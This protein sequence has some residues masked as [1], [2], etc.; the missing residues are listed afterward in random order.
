MLY[1]F[2]A[3]GTLTPSRDGSCG[4]FSFSLLPGVKQ[5]CAELQAAGH[6]LAIASNQSKDRDIAAILT[7]LTWTANRLGI[8]HLYVRYANTSVRR[9]PKPDMLLELMADSG[10][11]A[12]DTVF[13]GD[14][15][16]DRQA[17]EAAGVSFFWA[18]DFFK[19]E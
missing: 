4:E 11:T 9:K 8:F 1:I 2:D 18:N 10:Y 13:V 7:Q 17:A 5:K 6:T 19:E 16:T 3:D 12:A 14:Q 15:E